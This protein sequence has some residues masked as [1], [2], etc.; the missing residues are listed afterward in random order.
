MSDN[1]ENNINNGFKW[2]LG[3]SFDRFVFKQGK[4]G[5]WIR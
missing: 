1:I 4:Y 2:F 3:F 5:V